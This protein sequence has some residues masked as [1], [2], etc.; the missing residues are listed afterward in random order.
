MDKIIKHQKEEIAFKWDG[1]L[2]EDIQKAIDLKLAFIIPNQPDDRSLFVKTGEYQT[3][4][5]KE[6]ARIKYTN[7]PVGY[8]VVID[9]FVSDKD[10]SDIKYMKKAKIIKDKNFSS[11]YHIISDE[12]S[13]FDDES[14]E[15]NSE[16]EK[17]V[18][19]LQE[20]LKEAVKNFSD[21]T[22]I[23]VEVC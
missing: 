23:N 9:D 15:N 10:G 20:E 3:A 4:K 19:E 22:G 21:R 1:I 6:P 16:E 5:K 2:N 11:K 14:K 12:P 18:K 13:L 8:W 17:E 7:V